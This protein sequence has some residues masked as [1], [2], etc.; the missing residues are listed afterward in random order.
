LFLKLTQQFRLLDIEPGP[1]PKPEQGS[2]EIP[3][4][5]NNLMEVDLAA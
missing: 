4:V 3:A 2:A 1:E 5:I